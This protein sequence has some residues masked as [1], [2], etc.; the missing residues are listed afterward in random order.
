MEFGEWRAYVDLS[1]PLRGREAIS[2]R[3]SAQVNQI[4]VVM[5]R[6]NDNDEN[7]ITY[8]KTVQ[9]IYARDY[10]INNIVIT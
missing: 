6:D 7:M 9:R 8:R 10:N 1:L 2:E 4:K 5:E 3:P